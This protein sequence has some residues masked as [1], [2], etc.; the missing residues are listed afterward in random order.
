MCIINYQYY[1]NH[2]KGTIKNIIG[3]VAEEMSDINNKQ[4]INKNVIKQDIKFNPDVH[5]NSKKPSKGNET[6]KK[7]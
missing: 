2:N 7:C 1:F 4:S 5:K 3:G 6:R